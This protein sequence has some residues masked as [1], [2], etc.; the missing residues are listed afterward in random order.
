VFPPL[1][2]SDFLM[3]DK[4][5]AVNIAVHGLKG[6]V[7]VNGQ[8]YDNVMPPMGHLSDAELANILT[9]V[10]S[11]WGNSGEAVSPDEV[12]KERTKPPVALP[13]SGI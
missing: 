3:S 1:A 5:R 8:E 6:R 12:A 4:L 9:F 11:N 7:T 10:R 2:G 13:G